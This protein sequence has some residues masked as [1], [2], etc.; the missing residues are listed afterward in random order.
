[1]MLYQGRLIVDESSNS[2]HF[3]S[4]VH[5]EIHIPITATTY[6]RKSKLLGINSALLVKNGQDEYFFASFLSRD[7]CFGD[8]HHII[9]CIKV[10]SWNLQEDKV[11]NDFVQS[12]IDDV[13]TIEIPRILK[14]LHAPENS[15]PRNQISADI[16][17]GSAPLKARIRELED[18]IHGSELFQRHERQSQ[19]GKFR[20]AS[21]AATVAGTL[22]SRSMKTATSSK[23]L[24][25]CAE[26]LQQSALP[27]F[28][29]EASGWAYG[30]SRAFW[31]AAL[32]FVFANMSIACV[33]MRTVLIYFM[34]EEH[35]RVPKHMLSRLLY[36]NPVCLL[37]ST[38]LE[39]RERNP[40]EEVEKNTDNNGHFVCSM[41]AS[42]YSANI[43]TSSGTAGVGASF[44]LNIPTSDMTSLVARI[45]STSGRD[46]DKFNDLNI[47]TC[48]PGWSD[49]PEQWPWRSENISNSEI[50]RQDTAAGLV[51][52]KNCVAHLVCK[53]EDVS[54]RYGHLLLFA[55]ID[56]GYARSALWNGR[57]FGVGASD[58]CLSF[59]GSRVFATLTKMDRNDAAS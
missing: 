59:L 33:S 48:L 25:E 14:K 24:P 15:Y 3:K 7:S 35:V 51:A 31:V 2:L 46:G 5:R 58:T 10:A 11:G 40:N 8:I 13:D 47:E 55:V 50:L 37:T 30:G 43:L 23:E 38:N 36:P 12:P 17:V 22:H 9:N 53:V 16:I 32:I 21:D 41:K 57:N 28:Y 29:T 19:T 20:R 45:G 26:N 34:L 52:L 1:M 6:L 56:E 18:K 54:E 42:R 39:S 49:A 44:V 27:K 4:L